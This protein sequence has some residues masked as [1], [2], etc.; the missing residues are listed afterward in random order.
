MKAVAYIFLIIGIAIFAGAILLAVKGEVIA[1][2][3][4]FISGIADVF[5]AKAMSNHI[6]KEKGENSQ[7]IK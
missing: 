5:A 2:I 7:S 1:A 3:F 6:K 4:L